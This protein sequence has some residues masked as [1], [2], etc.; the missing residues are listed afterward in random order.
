MRLN[1]NKYPLQVSETES[2]GTEKRSKKKKKQFLTNVINTFAQDYQQRL[3]RHLLHIGHVRFPLWTENILGLYTVRLS[4]QVYF[5]FNRMKRVHLIPLINIVYLL[6]GRGEK[7]VSKT[8]VENV[9]IENP[10]HHFA[11]NTA[12]TTTTCFKQYIL[13]ATRRASTFRIETRNLFIKAHVMRCL[14][15]RCRSRAR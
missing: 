3:S 2:H 4:R 7:N 15:T 11:G 10:C 6:Y 5:L 13:I 14:R 8:R 1:T 12:L 9:L